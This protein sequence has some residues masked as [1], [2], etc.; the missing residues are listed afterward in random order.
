MKIEPKIR[1]FICTTAHPVGCEVQLQQQI[2]KVRKKGPIQGGSKKALIIGASTGYGM[3]SRVALAF[4]CGADTLGIYFE[5]EAEK[6]RTATPGFYQ[7]RALEVKA[8]KE[9]TYAKSINGDA[10]SDEIKQQA[11]ATI[12][13][14]LGTV[15]T[16]IYS[17]AAPRRVLPKTGEASRSTLKPIGQSFTSK[18]L[19]VNSGVVGEIFLEAASEEEVRQTIDVMGGEDWEMWMDA[20]EAAGVLAPGALTV[21]YSYIGP[22]I[23][24][25]VYRNGTIGAAKNHLERTAHKL[26]AKMQAK[27][28]RAFVSVNKAVVTQASSAIPVMPLYIS[29]LYRVMKEKGVHEGYLEQMDRLF[30]EKLYS[31][32]EIPVDS[33]GRIRVDDWEMLED[34]QKEVERLWPLLETSNVLSLTDIQGYRED[35]L[36]LFG[37]G[38]EG[39]DYSADVDDNLI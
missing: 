15:D 12:K 17:L 28:G 11:I 9:G 20:L 5:R 6:G 34:V 14:D 21:A 27:G 30:R 32:K 18:T 1:G 31:G 35:F 2:D 7:S 22:S 19:D 3:A 24:V 4:G 10:F 29:V 26:Q 13:Q 37:F 38:V 39:V 25:P 8:Q 23:T 36:R 33:E 16:V